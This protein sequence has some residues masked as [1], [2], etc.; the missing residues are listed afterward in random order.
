MAPQIR[1]GDRWTRLAGPPLDASPISVHGPRSVNLPSLNSRD[2]FLG[3]GLGGD[4]LGDNR[5]GWVSRRHF[6]G[7]VFLQGAPSSKVCSHDAGAGLPT[8][9]PDPNFVR[10]WVAE[11]TLL[12]PL[13]A[14]LAACYTF[15]GLFLLF[16]EPACCRG[17]CATCER[18]PARADIKCRMPPWPLISNRYR[19]V[20]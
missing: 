11:S 4:L 8:P 7:G 14:L 6:Q 5:W 18:G 19:T 16:G 1:P 20:Q 13:P 15:R 12:P 17:R 10:R 9:E 3:G 2:L